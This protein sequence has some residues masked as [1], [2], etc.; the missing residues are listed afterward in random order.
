MVPAGTSILTG[1]H[2]YLLMYSTVLQA[3]Y[4]YRTHI[5]IYGGTIRYAKVFTCERVSMI[6]F[7]YFI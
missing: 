1:I 7:F 4:W 6:K 5:L 3:K 2:L